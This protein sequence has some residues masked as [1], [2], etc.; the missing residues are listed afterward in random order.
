MYRSTNPAKERAEDNAHPTER[1]RRPQSRPAGRAAI[2]PLA[3]ADAAAGSPPYAK[4]W[5][6]RRDCQH[7]CRVARLHR[8]PPVRGAGTPRPRRVAVER[9]RLRARRWKQR[10]ARRSGA[11]SDPRLFPGRAAIL[12]HDGGLSRADAELQALWEICTL[13][14]AAGFPGILSELAQADR[15]RMHPDLAPVLAALGLANVRGP[16]WDLAMW[17]P[18]ARPPTGRRSA[19]RPRTP[20]SSSLP[21]S[22][23]SC[24]IWSQWILP[25]GIRQH[26]LALLP[27][28]AS[29]RS[30]APVCAVARS[31]YSM[32]L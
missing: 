5:P 26:G 3:L 14:L 2:E 21:S 4:A 15:R 18:M 16:A 28:S 11:A 22:M 19:P 17:L 10:P 25:T 27:L 12:E 13:K 9:A 20:R 31:L 30:S 8:G 23:A 32:I 29:M 6:A 7:H 24:T 1:R